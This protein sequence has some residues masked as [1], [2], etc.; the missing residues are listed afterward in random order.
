MSKKE[1]FEYI[2]FPLDFSTFSEAKKYI[3]L[4]KDHVGL[5]K[6]GLEL[7]ISDGPAVL[8][9]LTEVAPGKIFLDLKFHDI[10]ETV[11]RAQRAADRYGVAFTTVHCSDG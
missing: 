10:S 6:V 2:V 3:E 5:F 1:G 8:E 9:Y 11:L 4:L 7:F